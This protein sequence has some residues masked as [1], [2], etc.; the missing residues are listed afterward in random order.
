MYQ[1]LSNV[2]TEKLSLDYRNE[3]GSCYGTGPSSDREATLNV[4]ISGSKEGPPRA[5]VC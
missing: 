5:T 1:E 3:P 4:W 2:E